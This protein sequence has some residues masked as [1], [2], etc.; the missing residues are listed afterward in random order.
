MDR[1]TQRISKELGQPAQAVQNV[2]DLLDAG[3]TIPFIARYRKEAHGAMDDE[4]L[5]SLEERL[6]YLR[7]LEQRREEMA[8]LTAIASQDSRAAD[9]LRQ[10]VDTAQAERAVEDTLLSMGYGNAVCIL[11]QNRVTVCLGGALTAEQAQSVTAVCAHLT[12][13]PTDFVFILD[14]CAYL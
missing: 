9:Q 2:I 1:I 12:G 14:E 5:R 8:A 10:L 6:R 7:S 3:N 4:A 11:R 13:I